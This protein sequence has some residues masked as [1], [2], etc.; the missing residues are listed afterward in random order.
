MDARNWSRHL[1]EK[2]V[3]FALAGA[4][5][6]AFLYDLSAGGCMI[7]LPDTSNVIGQPLSIVLYKR[8]TAHGEVV[9]QLGPCVGVRFDTPIHDAV[10]R[11][12]GFT[13]PAIAF[14]DQAPRDR[15][16]RPLPP[17]DSGER[18]WI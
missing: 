14:E 10:V 3:S 18:G 4:R 12:V 9:W 7:E 6:T 13:P 15:F 8:E 1:V 11:H 5:G 2:E 17:L 16:G